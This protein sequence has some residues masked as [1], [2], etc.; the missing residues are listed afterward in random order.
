MRKPRAL[1]LTG[2]GINC[3][4]ET[5]H[6]FNLPAVGGDGVRVHLNDLIAAPQML[7]DYQIFAIPGGFSFG[8]DIASGKVLAVK[9]RGRL[10]EPLR[11]QEAI[12][13]VDGVEDV[14]LRVPAV[15]LVLLPRLGVAQDDHQVTSHRHLPARRRA[16]CGSRDWRRCRPDAP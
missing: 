4:Y 2:Y 16:S 8:D 14:H 10:L 5:A 12:E 13:L 9:L 3:D 1:V 6:A 11:G 15:E 7:R